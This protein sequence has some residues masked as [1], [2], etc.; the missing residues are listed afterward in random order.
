MQKQLIQKSTSLNDVEFYNEM[1]ILLQKTKQWQPKSEHRTTKNIP[2]D[3]LGATSP[4]I[5]MAQFIYVC[6][7]EIWAIQLESLVRSRIL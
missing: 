5:N 2:T 7:K 4:I 6:F 1:V 3:L